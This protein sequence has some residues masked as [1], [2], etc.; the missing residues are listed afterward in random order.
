VIL[1]DIPDAMLKPP[2]ETQD[3][4]D[5]LFGRALGRHR[6]P[7]EI[8]KPEFPTVPENREAMRAMAAENDALRDALTAVGNVYYHESLGVD[9]QAKRLVVTLAEHVAALAARLDALA[10]QLNNLVEQLSPTV[11]PKSVDQ[12]RRNRK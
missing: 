4:C 5:R 8:V 10:A 6:W 1:R 9:A 7:G 12:L 11:R 3:V 2:P